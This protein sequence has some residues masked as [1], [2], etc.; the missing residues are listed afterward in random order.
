MG[1]FMCMYL[2]ITSV[3]V[4]FEKMKNITVKK[5]ETAHLRQEKCDKRNVTIFSIYV[6]LSRKFDD[7]YSWCMSKGI[8]KTVKKLFWQFVSK[9]DEKR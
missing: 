7:F 3:F 6:F 8:G 1:E 5:C 9:L 2:Y 4:C